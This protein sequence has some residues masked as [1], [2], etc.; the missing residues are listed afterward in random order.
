MKRS[1]LRHVLSLSLAVISV[2]GTTS[3]AHAVDLTGEIE[4][5]NSEFKNAL[6]Y[7]IIIVDKPDFQKFLAKHGYENTDNEDILARGLFTYIKQKHGYQMLP[8]EA[9]T[10]APSFR[11]TN[12]DAS[13]QP[14]YTEKVRFNQ[15]K[16]CVVIPSVTNNTPLEEIKRITGADTHPELFKN[17]NFEKAMS[18]LSQEEIQLFSLYHELSHCLDR[19]YIAAINEFEV[20]P[21]NLHLTEAFAETNALF[22]L[23]QRHR[24]KKL[25]APRSILRTL[26]SKYYGPSLAQK[27]S[28]VYASEATRAG[29]SVYFL[30]PVL[31]PAQKEIDTNPTQIQSMSLEQTLALSKLI[32]DH[33]AINKT[34]FEAMHMMMKEGPDVILPHYQRLAAKKPSMFLKPYQDLLYFKSVLDSVDKVLDSVQS[35]QVNNKN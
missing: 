16:Y 22:M 11:P 15:M 31:L 18:L 21:H 13:A 28:N 17:F 23:F 10:L 5:L 6:G 24:L 2:L 3:V 4:K 32:V 27:E 12:K 8:E 1:I 14:F 7:P 35:V 20:V 25:G 34:S 33:H 26:Y 30:S 9:G 19:N 29:G